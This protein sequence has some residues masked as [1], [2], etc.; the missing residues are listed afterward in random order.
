MLIQNVR[1]AIPSQRLA[2]TVHEDVLVIIRIGYT[3]QAMQRI[4][5]LTPQWQKSF[6]FT[7]AAQAYLS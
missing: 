2:M 7:L 3:P 1:D 6:L 4:G 5:R